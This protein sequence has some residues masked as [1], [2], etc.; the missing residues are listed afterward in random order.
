MLTRM[1]KISIKRMKRSY[2][3]LFFTLVFGIA[4]LVVSMLMVRTQKMREADTIL[5]DYGNYDIAFCDS[6]KELEKEI[7]NDTRF[8]KLGYVYDFGTVS[9]TQSGNEINLGALKD[10]KTEDMLYINP[11]RGRYP[12]SEGEI[13]V[14][15][16]TLK[17]GGYSEKL[18]QQISLSYLDEN[19]TIRY[20]KFKLVGII[21]VQKQDE[22]A[23]YTSRK[24][25]EKMFSVDQVN[26]IGFPLAYISV[27]EARKIFTKSKR[28]I[29]ANVS[30]KEKSDDVFSSYLGMEN[31]TVDS[32]LTEKLH[33]DIDHVFGREWAAVCIVGKQM[34]NG[35]I[36]D[37]LTKSVEQGDVETDVYTKYFIPIFMVLILLISSVGI[38]D[39]IRLSVEERREVYG[40][41]LGMG[42]TGLRILGYLVFEFLILLIVS[43][44]AGW[45]LGSLSYQLAL[46]GI[47]K[48]FGIGLPSALMMDE[49]FGFYI[50]MATKNPWF[51]S[52][53]IAS[54]VTVVG[55]IGVSVDLLSMTPIK[56]E[57]SSIHKKRRRKQSR[58][59]SYLINHYVGKGS[60]LENCI[61]Y[62]MVCVLMSVSIFGFLF[63]RA[64][65]QDDTRQMTERIEN[66]RINGMDYY[67]KQNS[68]VLNGTMQ[69]MHNS[70]VT[71][72]AFDDLKEERSVEE[73]KG[74][75]ENNS[76]MLLYRSE[77]MIS[78]V[79]KPQS[80][81]FNPIDNDVNCKLDAKANLKYFQSMGIDTKKQEVFHIPTIGVRDE[82]LSSFE[83]AVIKGEFHP[84]KLKTGKEVL[85]VV[86]DESLASYFVPGEEL[87]L[88]DVVRPK[89]LDESQEILSGQIPKS[90]KVKE[91][92]YSVTLDGVTRTYYRYDS[93]KSCHTRIGAVICVD[94][95]EYSFYFHRGE[96]GY[97]VNLLTGKNAFKN[98]GLSNRNY[99]SVGV[100][101]KDKKGSETF[102]STWMR[103][104]KDAKY[105]DSVDVYSVLRERKRTVQQIMAIFY[106]VFAVL[107]LIGMLCISNSIAMRMCG[108]EKEQVILYNLGLT[109]NQILN[110]YI[111]R[112]ARLGI[113]G[114]V[115]S[116]IPVVIYTVLEKYASDLIKT[117]NKMDTINALFMQKPW[118]EIIPK[119]EMINKEFVVVILSGAVISVIV[120]SL[121]VLLQNGRLN[122][123]L[124]LNRQEE[125]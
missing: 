56:L 114:A 107:L 93:L 21:E 94:A 23:I 37:V 98:W 113:V 34:E 72:E 55:I 35:T 25:P 61:P 32:S 2:L 8:S 39:V 67:M 20:R 38:Y 96:T 101:L 49:Y 88:Y 33:I 117:A 6:T 4:A 106:F 95:E 5:Q 87:S 65:S 7:K 51:W 29:L 78:N 105:M 77:D 123:T 83:D 116:V 64:K 91:K 110:I 111:K 124:N 115:F 30:L 119:Y 43:I 99:T 13:C 62:V 19:E 73:V 44:F 92:S 45:G 9:L 97:Q 16:L 41:L 84:D 22:G 66:A 71:E 81:Y 17:S 70:G 24:Y 58:N 12:K 104:L 121:L 122:K 80:E 85:V 50:K 15:R 57:H 47:Q 63:F 82:D 68:T 18:G 74:V 112:Y 86:T 108:M 100:R 118:V 109:K 60:F 26:E 52:A 11:V 28:H 48:I 1:L 59:I 120:I 53:V 54:L 27:D 89:E 31:G 42:M 40:I 46:M 3:L 79:L 36:S 14:D 75:V 102:D 90:Y 103:V 10:Q 76:T 125:E 69:Y